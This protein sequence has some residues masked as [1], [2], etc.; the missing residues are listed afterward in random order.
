MERRLV[1]GKRTFIV[2]Q[3][4]EFE[5]P[6]GHSAMWV[7]QGRTFVLLSDGAAAGGAYW[8]AGVEH[9]PDR[10]RVELSGELEAGGL[11]RGTFDA[12]Y[13]FPVGK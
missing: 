1:P 6:E 9:E 3:G 13:P 10:V 7:G 2:W 8:V 11:E 12:G 4:H 5:L